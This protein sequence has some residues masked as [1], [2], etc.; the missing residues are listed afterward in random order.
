MQDKPLYV[1]YEKAVLPQ[2]GIK[3]TAITWDGSQDVGPD[4][5]VH[6]FQIGKQQY[7]LVFEDYD[8]K[9]RDSAFIKEHVAIRSPKFTFVEPEAETNSSPSYDGFRLPTPYQYCHNVTGTFTLLKLD[10]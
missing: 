5:T 7:A 1:F 6:Y 9:G 3:D 10:S 4:E 2:F 8:G